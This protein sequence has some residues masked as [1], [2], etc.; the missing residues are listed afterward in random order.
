LELQVALL[1]LA[2]QNKPCLYRKQKGIHEPDLF[3]RGNIDELQVFVFQ[4][5]IYFQASSGEFTEDLEQIFFA[6]SYLRGVALDYFEPFINE[7]DLYQIY[8][9]LKSWPAF[10]QKLSNIFR[11]YLPE[12]NNKDAIVS[13]V[14][15]SD[16]KVVTYFIQFAKFQNCICWDDKSLCKVV[17]NAIL[18]C[19]CSELHFCKE[20][21]SMF[22]GLKQAVLKIDNNYWKRIQDNK[23]RQCL[24]CTFQPSSTKTSCNTL[25]ED[26]LSKE[27]PRVPFLTVLNQTSKQST[28]SLPSILG[29]DG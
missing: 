24:L 17:K 25:L 28:L 23:N 7:A 10:I 1:I 8:D 9:F 26:Q 4:C 18:P 16:G 5:Q 27:R 22:K 6:I 13:L 14:F 20:D 21:M 11:S 12:D 29:P 19:I 3:N 15:L 2:R